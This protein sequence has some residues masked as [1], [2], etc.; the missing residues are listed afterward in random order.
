MMS[1]LVYDRGMYWPKLSE[2][3][4]ARRFLKEIKNLVAAG[5]DPNVVG[6]SVEDARIVEAGGWPCASYRFGRQLDG[7]DAVETNCVIVGPEFVYQLSFGVAS[8]DYL[9]Q[10]PVIEHMVASFRITA[11]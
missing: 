3:Q 6:V 4:A 10:L 5:T 9:T 1:I 8:E 2:R 7:R 11:E